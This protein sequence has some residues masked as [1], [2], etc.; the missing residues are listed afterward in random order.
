MSTT[1]HPDDF[2]D[3][4]TGEHDPV[5]WMAKALVESNREGHESTKIEIRNLGERFEASMGRWA[6]VVTGALGVVVLSICIVGAVVGVKV[7]LPDGT[8]TGPSSEAT[9]A[10]VE[11]VEADTEHP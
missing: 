5:Q 11:L 1:A 7:L 4:P 3:E 6:K 8:S 2:D 10:N 9:E